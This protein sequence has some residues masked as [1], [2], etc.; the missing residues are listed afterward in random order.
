MWRRRERPLGRLLGDSLIICASFAAVI[1]V[2]Q[3]IIYLVFDYSFFDTARK[4]L[5]WFANNPLNSGPAGFVRVLVGAFLA[6][7]LLVPVGLLDIRRS[8]QNRE[9]LLAM[10]IS[11]LLTLAAVYTN[12]IRF[13]FVLFPVVFP[14]AVLGVV[15]LAKTGRSALRFG[16][17]GAL[18]TEVVLLSVVCAFS[19]LTYA[20]FLRYGST[21]EMAR[22]FLQF[23]V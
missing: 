14:I 16:S 13:V 1:L 5:R 20:G 2:W 6:S 12:S 15:R 9:L 3:L 11:G 8:M 17:L 23:L 21:I 7:L 19:L 4:Q 22:R 10:L 18:I